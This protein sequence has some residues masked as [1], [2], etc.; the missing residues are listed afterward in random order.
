MADTIQW[1]EGLEDARANAADSDT[2]V[3]TYIHAPG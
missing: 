1:F 2:I 3:L